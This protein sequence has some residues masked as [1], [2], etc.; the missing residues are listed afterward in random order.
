MSTRDSVP[1]RSKTW[2]IDVSLDVWAS[3]NLMACLLVHFD[4]R[5]RR[6]QS[7]VELVWTGDVLRR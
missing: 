3:G 4:A 5:L 6:L 7:S 2:R 1:A